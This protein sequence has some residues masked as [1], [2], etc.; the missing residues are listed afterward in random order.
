M[1]SAEATSELLAASDAA[2]DDAASD[3]EAVDYATRLNRAGVPCE[4]HVYAGAPPR[5]TP[6][7]RRARRDAT[8][9]LA[10]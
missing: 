2:S 9:W 1:R 7:A 5:D 10:A 4:L 6:L 3:D 8:D